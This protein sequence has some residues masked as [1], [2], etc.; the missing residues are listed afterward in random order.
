MSGDR[1]V[2]WLAHGL[3]P[4][5]ELLGALQ[6]KEL[7]VETCTNA[8]EALARLCRTTRK[9][10]ADSPPRAAVLLLCDPDRLDRVG[11]MATLAERY[12]PRAKCWVFDS[13]SR[14]LRGA[15]G[16]DN[17]RWNSPE[18]RNGAGLRNTGSSD[19][20]PAQAVRLPASGLPA[21]GTSPTSAV[22]R[23]SGPP[24]LRLSGSGPLAPRPD[25]DAAAMPD[26]IMPNGLSGPPPASH[27]PAGLL[28][29]EELAMLLS[30]DD[31]GRQD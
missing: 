27:V 28:S 18:V 8:Y 20:A 30:P 14:R 25:E 24:A 16:E 3:T 4:D 12:A 11:E 22:A 7:N 10:A 19:S 15:T 2:L 31:P 29:D 23:R 6:R 17:A 13:T 26:K 9:N 5:T 21:P 1:C